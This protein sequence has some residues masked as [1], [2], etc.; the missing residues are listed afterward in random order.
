M[1]N[2]PSWALV[3][4]GK[5]ENCRSRQFLFTH[6]LANISAY[7][8]SGLSNTPYVACMYCHNKAVRYISAYLSDEQSV[9][10][11]YLRQNEPEVTVENYPIIADTPICY[12]CGCPASEEESLVPAHLQ[13]NC[14]IIVQVHDECRYYAHCCDTHYIN[15]RYHY[16]R[17]SQVDRPSEEYV[18]IISFEGRDKCLRCV[19]ALLEESGLTLENDYFEC[20]WCNSHHHED[21]I[22][23]ID[24]ETYCERC[25]DRHRY[26]CDSCDSHYWEGDDHDCDDD[27]DSGVIHDYS[28]KPRP[29]F[30]PPKERSPD[31]R[32][33]FGIEL[34]VEATR[35][36][37]L[38]CAE[39]V[40]ANLGER[41]YLKYDGSLNNGFE[42][43]TH[44]HTLE[45][46]RKDFAFDKFAIFRRSGL[47]SWDTST[48]GLHVH[49]SRDA[50]GVPYDSRT[51]NYS[52]HI[53]SRQ[54]HEVRFMKLIYDNETQ[55]CK[56]AG[57][58]S[59]YAHFEDK[60]NLM[61]KARG[62]G[63]DR[64]V[65]VN[66][67]NDTTLEVRIFKG[68]LR[69]ERVLGA[70]EFVHAGVEYTRNLKVNGKNRALSWLAFCGYVHANQEQYSNLYSL[71]LKT[72]SDERD[73]ETQDD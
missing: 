21:Y 3:E 70:I 67:E 36:E 20:H 53:N 5:C 8:E 47:R 6:S 29:Y 15:N 9:A 30:F 63:Y 54:T 60:G 46:F 69:P 24:G 19:N 28:Y 43:V 16:N 59:G 71:M 27:Y 44:P 58:K 68:S 26:Y 45:A 66:T 50:F 42:I 2:Q 48:C 38:E 51:D 37:R 13:N 41:A 1:T 12:T 57:R 4:V 64:H 23:H 17:F 55:V 31:T 73:V 52:E 22:N 33:Y 61:S 35:G 40:Q 72:F 62:P 32:L 39:V 18:R 25:V 7:Y 10:F 49:V 65:A 14:T 56:L 34:E 11:D